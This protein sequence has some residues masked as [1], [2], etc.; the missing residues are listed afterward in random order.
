MKKQL[1]LIGAMSATSLFAQTFSDNFDSYTAGQYMAAQSGGNWTTWSGAP[2][3]AEDVLVSNANSVSPSNS[4]YFSSNVSGGGTTDLVKNFG[5]LNTGQFSLQFNMFVEAGKAAYFNLQRN[6]VIGQVWAMD[7]NFND[8]GTLSIINQSGLNFNTTYTQ[9]TWFNFRLD[10][11]FNSNQ[12]EVFI[13][14]TSMGTF[15]NP[16]NQ[17]A[18]ID[19]YPVD[20]NTPFAAG[21]FI[22]DF[23]YTI[24]PYTLPSV[25]GAATL[26]SYSEAAL[27]GNN[28]TPKVTVRNLGTTPITSFDLA[29]T[30]NGNTINK[31]VTGVNIASLATS[32]IT[33]DNTMT[34]AAG[35]NNMVATISN[36]NG[37][38]A[39]GDAADDQT[40]LTINPVVPAAGKMVVGEEGT[41]T[42]CGWCPRGAVF[43][44]QMETKY[45]DY[46]AGIAVH[47]GDPMTVTDYDAEIGNLIAGYPSG[48][49]DR[50]TE[51][52]PSE[53]EAEFLNRLVVAPTAF[54][55][56]GAI[57]DANT[58]TLDVSVTADFQSAANNNYK[59]AIVLTED[60]VTGTGSTYNQSN[61]YAGG[62]SGVMGGF[63]TLPNP[64]PAAQMTYDHVARVI[65]PSFAGSNASFPAT[66]AAGETHTLTAQFTLPAEWDETQIHI[67]GMLIA[68]NGTIDNAGK[69]TIAE[70]VTNGWVAGTAENASILSNSVSIYPNPAADFTTVNVQLKGESTLDLTIL[71]MNGK[72]L[73]SRN[74]GTV[75][76]AIELPVNTANFENG[77]YIA[78]VTINGV[79]TRQLFVVK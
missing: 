40:S 18:S 2:G 5:V 41:G 50:G 42:W 25:N 46:W 21:Y 36:V 34:L 74:Y 32:V 48:L 37:A 61:Y 47:N 49:V 53:F 31:T 35:S 29:V 71:D 58:R 65:A 6:A 73:A 45:A 54:I 4:V 64:V 44:G 56:N 78:V 1:L 51:R 33:M 68:P 14:N 38:G 13:D 7:C 52:D 20:Q 39:D 30:Y 11:N 43:M 60:D 79:S 62:G 66:I 27:A 9:G 26:V 19:I 67:I 63:E 77:T 69:A 57:W 23:E 17:I 22:D 75:A 10:I 72:V 59:L 16:E 70:A 28:V 12:W 24:T 76:G 3:G 55:Q 15:A 8:D